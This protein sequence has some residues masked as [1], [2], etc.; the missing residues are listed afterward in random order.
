[1][2]TK[3][4]KL[5]KKYWQYRVVKDKDK[6]GNI[7]FSVRDVYFENEKPYAWGSEPQFPIGDTYEEVMK[8]LQ[9]MNKAL[10]QKTLI[11]KGNTLIEEKRLGI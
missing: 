9:F 8:D 7:F 2:K 6:K 1:M 3:E 10:L 5:P 11:V 4:E